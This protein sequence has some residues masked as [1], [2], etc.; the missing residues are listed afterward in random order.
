MLKR[1]AFII[2]GLVLVGNLAHAQ[3]EPQTA[4]KILPLQAQCDSFLPMANV[5]SKYG[6]ELL[7]TGEGITMAFGTGQSYRGGMGFFTNQDTGTWTM[8]QLFQDGTACLLF[9]GSKFKPFVGN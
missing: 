5:L 9:N 2:V 8:I 6:E 4:P 1:L 7:F 3:E